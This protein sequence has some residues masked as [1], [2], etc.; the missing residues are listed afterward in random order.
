MH[1]LKIGHGLVGEQLGA[2]FF[3]LSE[4]LFVDLHAGLGLLLEQGA[5][6]VE[7]VVLVPEFFV[8]DEGLDFLVQLGKFFLANN[9]LA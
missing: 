3:E 8:G 7:H 5:A 6:L 9:G 1:V 4:F 2:E